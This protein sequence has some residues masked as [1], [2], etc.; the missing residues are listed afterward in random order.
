MIVP[1]Y[2]WLVGLGKRKSASIRLTDL[3]F[4]LSQYIR[5]GIGYTTI[6]VPRRLDDEEN[7]PLA[8]WPK[9]FSTGIVFQA[10]LTGIGEVF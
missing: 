10:T 7:S 4:A 8:A 9:E 2:G 5:C 3:L 1:W 6:L